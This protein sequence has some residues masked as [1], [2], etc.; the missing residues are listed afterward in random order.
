MQAKKSQYEIYTTMLDSM[1]KHAKT[2]LQ[3]HL[4][5]G[6]NE[7]DSAAFL[8]SRTPAMIEGL[9]YQIFSEE[10]FWRRNGANTVF[11][12]STAVLDNLL[13]ARFKME[14]AEGFTLPFQSFMFAMP[15]GF[16]FDGMRIPSFV[17]TWIPYKQ[18]GDLIFMPFA[19][20]VRIKR[21]SVNLTE[22]DRGD[23]SISLCYRDPADPSLYARTMIGDR[24]VPKLLAAQTPEEF[25][26]IA[27][28]YGDIKDVVDATAHDHNLQRVMLRLVAAFGIYNMA[29]DGENLKPGFPGNNKPRYVGHFPDSPVRFMTLRSSIPPQSKEPGQAKES[30]HRT[31]F[32]RQLRADQYYKGEYAETPKGTRYVFVS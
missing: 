19:D 22:D 5:K 24:D 1:L 6:A 29:T 16:T 23:Y 32:F 7:R 28:E 30:F 12:E 9:N 2:F 26:A 15:Q 17:V 13:R 4:P 10:L 11:P 3:A 31:W 20:Y 21:P 18:L 8:F 25:A 14:A 27:G